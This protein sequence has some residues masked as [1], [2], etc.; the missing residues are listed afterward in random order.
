MSENNINNFKTL[1]EQKRIIK[2]A[3]AK[4]LLA[5]GAPDNKSVSQYRPVGILWEDLLEQIKSE[6]GTGTLQDLASVLGVGNTT[7]TNDILVNAL[8]SIYFGGSTTDYITRAAGASA[9]LEFF[10]IRAIN[11]YI[12]T[13]GSFSHNATGIFSAVNL[14]T[15]RNISLVPETSQI[16]ASNGV[17][18]QGDI[19]FGPMTANPTWTM[20]DATGTV[21][22]TSAI[23]EVLTF[24]GG[25]SGD[26]AT[27][28]VTGG[29]ITARTLVP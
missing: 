9:N 25:A 15:S 22:L 26:V 27:M 24:G 28:T 17:G 13:N 6:V 21:A 19:D 4:S 5:F 7:G 3:I 23:T 18:Q 8:Q 16:V 10:A 14:P 2:K 1:I 12:G 11:F 29:I 20:P